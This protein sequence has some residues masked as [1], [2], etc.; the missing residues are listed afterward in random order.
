MRVRDLV[1]ITRADDG[2]IEATRMPEPDDG[3]I[4][5]SRALELGNLDQSL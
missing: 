2:S 1:M 5:G 4:G 3:E